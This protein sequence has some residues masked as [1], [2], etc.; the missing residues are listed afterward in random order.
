[1]D[2]NAVAVLSS[3]DNE[4]SRSAKDGQRLRIMTTPIIT[5]WIQIY[6]AQL[7]N[8]S[9]ENSSDMTGLTS[10]LVAF[11]EKFGDRVTDNSDIASV[12]LSHL[13]ECYYWLTAQMF[14]FLTDSWTTESLF[15][16]HIFLL[17]P[18][19]LFSWHMP[20]FD[21]NERRVSGSKYF[22]RSDLQRY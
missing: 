3:I 21:Q 2:I 14:R 15:S 5:N 9:Q 18:L 8:P 19:F 1:M 13:S 4:F 16:S 7:S 6:V 20:T 12:C 17:H 22:V 10:V 11:L